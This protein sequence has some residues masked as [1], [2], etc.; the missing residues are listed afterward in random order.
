MITDQSTNGTYITPDNGAEVYLRR[1][2]LVLQG[3][4]TIGLGKA[5]GESDPGE[6]IRYRC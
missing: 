3:S 2:E 6:L 4:G 5:T 1:E